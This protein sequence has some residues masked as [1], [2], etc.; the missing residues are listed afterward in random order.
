MSSRT[1][2]RPHML[3]GIFAS[4][5]IM[6]L[7]LLAGYGLSSL[8]FYLVGTP[9]EI[10]AL[11]V[12]GL[13][14]FLILMVAGKVFARTHRVL[15]KDKPFDFSRR[16]YSQDVVEAMNR[17]AEGDFS[18]LLPVE[19]LDPMA[20][21][22]ESVNKMARELGS[23]ENFRQDFISNVS[24]EIQS[25]LTSISGFAELL[26]NEDLKP[27]QR[28]HYVEVIEIEAKRLSKLSDNLLRLSELESD[29][30]THTF[31]EF[32]LDKQVKN[33]VLML[34][35]QWSSKHLDVSLDLEELHFMGDE[36]LLTQVW[37]NLLQNAI[38]FTPKDGAVSVVLK[39]DDE[40]IVCAISDTGVG[41]SEEDRIHIF[42]RFYKADKSRDRAL[43][44]NGLGLALVK[45]IVAL[46][47]GSVSVESALDQGSTF[48]VALPLEK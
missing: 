37:T 33:A 5:L 24:H 12:S 30:E 1:R 47:G 48:F 46:H 42:E 45:K 8:F 25:P 29:A 19:R 32:R 7:C 41:I 6:S 31:C 18:V 44:G 9:P 36:Y 2:K 17:I 13:L 16:R 43:G 3:A 4:L 28:R 14:G 15:R 26:K 23:M 38:K 10:V 35:P 22:A 40:E 21:I 20:P 27:E 39:K 34:E 11:L